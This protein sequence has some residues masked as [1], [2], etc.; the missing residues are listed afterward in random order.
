ML[1]RQLEKGVENLALHLSCAL[2][3]TGHPEAFIDGLG[4]HNVVPRVGGGLPLGHGRA[5]HD[6]NPAD[7]SQDE[8]QHLEPAISHPASTMLQDAGPNWTERGAEAGWGWRWRKS[9]EETRPVLQSGETALAKEALLLLS[10]LA[11]L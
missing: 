6:A 11:L 5:D 1:T 9:P 2:Y 10:P 8:A 7:E 3:G 4:R